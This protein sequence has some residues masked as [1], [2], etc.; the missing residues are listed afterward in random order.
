MSISTY[1][2]LRPALDSIGCHLRSNP[3][4]VGGFLTAADTSMD[5]PVFLSPDAGDI[6]VDFVVIA[7]TSPLLLGAPFVETYG[8]CFYWDSHIMEL[9]LHPC[10]ESSPWS[11]ESPRLTLGFFVDSW[12]L[13]GP[14]AAAAGR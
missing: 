12:T 13:A 3:I 5:V 14:K 8:A 6:L 9:Y 1:E 11:A 2:V 7:C 4:A 10:S